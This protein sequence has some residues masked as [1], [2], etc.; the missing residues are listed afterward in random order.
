MSGYFQRK[1]KR[2]YIKCY[3]NSDHLLKMSLTQVKRESVTN[4]AF[5]NLFEMLV[6]T[7]QHSIIF[8]EN[9]SSAMIKKWRTRWTHSS[10][11]ITRIVHYE[12]FIRLWNTELGKT[13]F[14][15]IRGSTIASGITTVDLQKNS[16]RKKNSF[17]CEA[18]NSSLHLC[19]NF[20]FLWA[21]LSSADDI[22]KNII[23]L[24]ISVFHFL[25]VGR[26]KKFITIAYLKCIS[27]N[28]FNVRMLMRFFL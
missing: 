5:A 20:C 16:F 3:Q 14:F 8:R 18:L 12:I 23:Q 19:S 22:T 26:T 10:Q 27:R 6:L 15:Y 24:W 1:Y 17:Q 28:L 4:E 25:S 11:Q 9:F 13:I 7:F 21:A 2:L